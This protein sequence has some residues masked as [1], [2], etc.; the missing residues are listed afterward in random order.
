MKKIGLTTLLMIFSLNANAVALKINE[1]QHIK[2]ATKESADLLIE[3]PR[4]F[5]GYIRSD[6]RLSQVTVMNSKGETVKQLINS[7]SKEVEIFWYVDK[8][9]HYTIE[10]IT[11]NK[12]TANIDVALNTMALQESQY[13]SPDTTITSPLILQTKNR[14]DQ[15]V[16]QAD[17]LFWQQVEQKGGTPLVEYTDNGT[18]L[19]TF[20]YKGFVDN[21]RILG[22]PY[23]GHIHLTQLDNSNIWFHSYEVPLET[24]FSYRV[25]PNVPQ[26]VDSKSRQQRRAV[27][28]TSQSDPLNLQPKFSENDNLFGAASTLTLPTAPKD[29]LTSTMGNPKGSVTDHIYQKDNNALARKISLYQPNK[30]YPIKQDAPLLILFDGDSYLNKVPTPVI[31]DNLI[32]QKLIPP[33]RAVFVN[34]PLPS[35]RAEELTPNTAYSEFLANEFMPWLCQSEKICPT[36][37]NTV[38]SGSSF[39]GLASMYIAFQHPERF[40][41]VLSQ[42]GSFWWSPEPEASIFQL[43]TKTET[44]NWMAE[45]FRSEPKK[46]LE[47]FLTAGLFEAKP[48]GKSILDTNHQVYQVLKSKGYSASIQ[49]AASGHDYFSWRV[50][51]ADGLIGLFNE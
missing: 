15:G 36:A 48:E 8:S 39:G 6:Q 13:V 1:P 44:D 28:A 26:L 22:A 23:E 27:L 20:L 14:L 7:P 42:S 45:L 24:R 50:M 40:G 9:D 51:L 41:K 47:I 4:Y 19:V 17:T 2:I 10:F 11:E 25:A 31:L 37:E 33:M 49:E 34:T 43:T 3:K 21:V 46:E 12:S 29:T 5:N 18:A 16:E 38:L 35:M 32:A 30:S